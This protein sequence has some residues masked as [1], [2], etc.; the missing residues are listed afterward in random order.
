MNKK[1]ILKKE[2]AERVAQGIPPTCRHP[3]IETKTTSGGILT[4]QCSNICSF[5]CPFRK[6]VSVVRN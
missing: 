4:R 2:K 1:D 5:S 6:G 3:N